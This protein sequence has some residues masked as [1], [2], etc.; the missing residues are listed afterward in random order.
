MSGNSLLIN[1]EQAWW[2]F[3]GTH[4]IFLFGKSM[5]S[6]YSFQ[7]VNANFG[8]FVGCQQSIDNRGGFGKRLFRRRLP[9]TYQSDAFYTYPEY[10]EANIESSPDFFGNTTRN[11]EC[12]CHT[13]S[14]SR[15]RFFRCI[16][17]LT[18][19]FIRLSG[20]TLFL[21]IPM[22]TIRHRFR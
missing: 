7:G 5:E 13:G 2:Q 3:K 9:H 16:H 6:Q 15:T 22:D 19:L 18:G 11:W 17:N 12:P 1:G 21:L 10:P 8:F 20:M 4:M 14:V